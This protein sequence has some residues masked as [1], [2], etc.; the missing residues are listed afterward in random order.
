MTQHPLRTVQYFCAAIFAAVLSTS[1]LEAQATVLPDTLTTAPTFERDKV[2]QT[3]YLER[4]G[5]SVRAEVDRDGRPTGHFAVFS[6]WPMGTK[7]VAAYTDWAY[8]QPSLAFVADGR[9][10]VILLASYTG[11]LGRDRIPDYAFKLLVLNDSG[12][13]EAFSLVAKEPLQFQSSDVSGFTRTGSG[14]F[15]LTIRGGPTFTYAQGRVVV[16]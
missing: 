9:P 12:P 1:L 6:T 4:Q 10:G 15:S 7:F 14:G 8:D 3:V 13:N 5:L 2:A 16:R 11:G